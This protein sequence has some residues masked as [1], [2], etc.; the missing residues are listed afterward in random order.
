MQILKSKSPTFENNY[1]CETNSK[2]YSKCN[3]KK[4]IIL[5]TELR[6]KCK[7]SSF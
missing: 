2:L 7:G 4:K 1:T 5:V 6:I 3:L